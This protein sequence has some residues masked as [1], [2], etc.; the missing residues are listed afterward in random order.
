MSM[1]TYCCHDKVKVREDLSISG[2]R[3]KIIASLC[4]VI[5]AAFCMY[6][7]FV[8][9]IGIFSRCLVRKEKSCQVACWGISGCKEDVLE[10]PPPVDTKKF[11]Q[12]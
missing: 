3:W 11:K 8:Y 5:F 12:T 9:F 10:A 1:L 7:T 2:C 4:F 6:T